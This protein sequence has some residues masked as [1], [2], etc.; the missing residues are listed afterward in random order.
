M[1]IRVKV[2]LLVL[3]LIIAPLLLTGFVASLSARNGITSVA[4]NL[5]A[6]KMNDLMNYAG[7]QW[8]LLVENDFVANPEYLAAARSAVS[9]Y[10]QTLIQSDSEL[11]FA[12]D[13]NGRV[14]MSTAPLSLTDAERQ[15]LERDRAAGAHGWL[16]IQAGGV[17]RVAQARLFEPFGWYFLVAERQ[18][19]FYRATTEIIMRTAIILAASLVIAIALLIVFSFLMTRPLRLV[20]TA[21][22]EI[23]QTNDLSRR[24]DILYRDETGELGHNFNLMT[25]EL[26]KA[27]RQIKGYALEAA[28]SQHREKKI[29]TIF[30]RYVPES[31]IN[32]FFARPE[33]MLTGQKRTLAILFSDIR[34][35]TSISEGLTSA[36]IVE[37]LNDYFA[38]MVEIIQDRYEGI[39]DKY[40]GDAIMAFFGAP[41][42]HED[43][44]FRAVMAGFEMLDSVRAFNAA[45]I[46]KGKPPFRI[47]VG[48]SYGEVTLGNIGS[49]K[50]MDYTIIGDEVNVA[51]RMEGLTKQYKEEIVVSERVQRFLEGKIPCRQIDKVRVVGKKEEIRI[52]TPHR[53]LTDAETEAWRVHERALDLY[54]KRDFRAAKST[55]EQVLHLLPEDVCAATFAQRCMKYVRHPPPPAWTGAFVLTEK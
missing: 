25:D 28:I 38:V 34:S 50:K 54:Y 46:S 7:S 12:L 15:A 19:T 36:Q 17:A 8:S 45:Q 6:F 2:V 35:F 1:S 9:S 13:Q 37:S 49:E 29:R 40:I 43:D 18:E 47:G 27:Y 23:M 32:E 55:F 51:S 52:F 14:A 10:A 20:A 21:M 48:I 24:V 3:P 41:L 53:V 42:K 30:Q 44:A 5:L 31:V 33:G 11:I 22:K 4:T 26:D 39:V 16:S